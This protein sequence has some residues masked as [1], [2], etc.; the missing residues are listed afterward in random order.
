MA[1]GRIKGTAIAQV[2]A[3]V[4]RL[5]DAGRIS[6]AEL[7]E[8]LEKPDRDLLET[9]IQLALWYDNASHA[10][11]TELLRRVEGGGRDEYVERRGA[12]TAERLLA[13]GLYEQLRLA[14]G[15]GSAEAPSAFRRSLRLL[16][17]L[18]GALY[19]FGTWRLR[20]AEADEREIW[21]DV[22]DAAAFTEMNRLTALGFIR[23]IAGRL[24]HRP[25]RVTSERPA[26]DRV[27]YRVE[28][29]SAD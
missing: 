18:S 10:R 21:I 4:C 20:S 1:T 27:S 15:H 12:E 6:E 11:L 29:A 19:D 26:P 22:T 17:T 8:A 5:R 28:L 7:E 24:Q 2:V 3:D 25:P 23:A 14:A 13:S 16:I 9:E